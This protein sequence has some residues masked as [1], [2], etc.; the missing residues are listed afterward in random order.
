MA[1]QHWKGNVAAALVG[2]AL[3]VALI[4]A[5]A[6]TLIAWKAATCDKVCEAEGNLR[7]AAV[8]DPLDPWIQERDARAAAARER[9]MS[10]R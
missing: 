1:W 4:Y 5:G 9:W 2:L 3:S 6:G 7:I 10:G 8:A